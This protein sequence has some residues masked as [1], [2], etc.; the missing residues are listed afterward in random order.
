MKRYFILVLI[1]VLALALLRSSIYFV[2]QAEY[3]YVT[4]FGKPVATFDGNS[5][6]GLK[7]KLPWPIQ[8]LTRLDHR[9]QA[10]DV[11]TQEFL[12][13]DRDETGNEKPLPLTFDL[14]IC[15]RIGSLDG[16]ADNDAVDRFI[17]S[18][19]SLDRAQ[20]YLRT[21]VVSRLKIELGDA[22]LTDLLNVDASKLK[23]N[24]LMERVRKGPHPHPLSPPGGEGRVRGSDGQ[25]SLDALADSVG[26]ALVD[27]RLRRF[28]HPLQVRDE[29]FAKIREERRRE[30][31][32]YRNQGLERAAQIR[33]EGDIE[34][35]RLRAE[36]DATRTRLEGQAEAESVRLLNDAAKENP[37][38]YWIVRLLKG[39]QKMFADD[40]TQ[41]ILSLD[42][43]LLS[44]F[45]NLPTFNGKS[46]GGQ[47]NGKAVVGEK[48]KN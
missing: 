27:V 8:S 38:L 34:A 45:K 48:G 22:L 46:I 21:Q 28:N 7:F 9:L 26:I 33:A 23:L 40:K 43:P 20:Q 5:D 6:A 10:F 3:V 18:F 19:G 29:I 13:R 47:N 39:N 31:E 11:P 17:R 24:A 25:Q 14:F 15:W 30:A 16:K 2:D 41:L 35:R 37:E 44:L 12:I 32:T 42:H 36:A 4:Q 1:L